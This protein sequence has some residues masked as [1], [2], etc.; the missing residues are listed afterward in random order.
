[1]LEM[2]LC[3]GINKI[4]FFK[5]YILRSI[6]HRFCKPQIFIGSPRIKAFFFSSSLN[7]LSKSAL[8]LTLF[9]YCSYALRSYDLQFLVLKFLATVHRNQDSNLGNYRVSLQSIR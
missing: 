4:T 2:K 8:Y 5:R 1:M 9:I 7:L 3:V 6:C